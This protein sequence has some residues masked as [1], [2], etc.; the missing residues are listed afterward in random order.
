MKFLDEDPK[1]KNCITHVCVYCPDIQNWL[2]LKN[3]YDLVYD[4]VAS[5][6]RVINFIKNL[7]QKK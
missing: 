2:H 5:K 3:K 4:F 1:I 6:D 7:F